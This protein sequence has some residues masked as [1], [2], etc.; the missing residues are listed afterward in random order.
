MNIFCYDC[1]MGVVRVEGIDA[2]TI[3]LASRI[4]S[5]RVFSSGVGLTYRSCL[6]APRM[7]H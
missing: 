7:M 4:G 2:K 6:A 1:E 3:S 5:G